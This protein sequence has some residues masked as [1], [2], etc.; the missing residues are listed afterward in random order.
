V[1]RELRLLRASVDN[2]SKVR[3]CS[4]DA[5][6]RC[7]TR[8]EQK[9]GLTHF[10]FGATPQIDSAFENIFNVAFY[11]VVLMVVLAVCGVNPLELFISV[12]AVVVAFAFSK[13]WVMAS[14][15]PLSSVSAHF[16]TSHIY[17]IVFQ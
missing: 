7:P 5:N 1:Y 14:A 3:I 17:F 6:R 11:I 15:F 12:S 8:L 10:S 9:K 16:I 13:S 2:S 4:C